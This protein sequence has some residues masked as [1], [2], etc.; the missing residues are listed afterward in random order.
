MT[1]DHHHRAAQAAAGSAGVATMKAIVQDAYG[2]A[3]EDVLR[4]AEAATPTV[5]DDEVLVRVRAAS[6]DRGTWH[7]MAGLP[8]AIRVAGFG[9]R[10]PKAPNPGRS[11]AGT[12]ESVGQDVTEFEPGDEVYGTCDG[13]LRRVRPR[14]SGTVR[15]GPGRRGYR[16]Q[17]GEPLLRAGGGRPRICAHRPAGRA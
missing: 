8:Y 15:W 10:R 5:G 12:V 9:L 13:F 3:P 16:P 11:V 4:L 7:G 1:T 14:P 2:S 6:V 17:T